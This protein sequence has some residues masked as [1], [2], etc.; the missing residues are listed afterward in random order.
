MYFGWLSKLNFVKDDDNE[1]FFNDGFKI[2][3]FIVICKRYL[4][5]IVCFWKIINLLL[6]WKMKFGNIVLYDEKL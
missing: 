2:V 4:K 5:F 1:I 6:M 3:C